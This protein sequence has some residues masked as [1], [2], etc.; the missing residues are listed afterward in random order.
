[1]FDFGNKIAN[2]FLEFQNNN[3]IIPFKPSNSH[4]ENVWNLQISKKGETKNF[5]F[6]IN[7]VF[8]IE[9]FF[10]LF[11][12]GIK[13]HIGIKKSRHF[14]SRKS[15]KCQCP[16]N[17]QVGYSISFGCKKDQEKVHVRTCLKA[18]EEKKFR[19]HKWL[20]VL[21]KVIVTL[22]FFGDMKS[23]LKKIEWI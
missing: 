7:F 2:I 10:F 22:K 23:D 16:I 21:K 8:C 13:N 1:M 11:N 20:F 17:L 14:L 3:I 9:R 12:I 15:F 19:I 6:S 5:I 4:S 18:F